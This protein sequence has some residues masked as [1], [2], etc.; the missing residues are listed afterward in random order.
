MNVSR[1]SLLSFASLG[2]FALLT[3]TGC[4]RYAPYDGEFFDCECGT[5]VWDGRELGMRMAE[6][7][8]LDSTTYRYHVIADLR[9]QEELDARMEPRNVI[10]T[11]TTSFVGAS[12]SLSLEAGD[13][14]MTVQEVD[15]PG[16]EVPWTMNGA[17]LAISASEEAHVMT[18]NSLSAKR[19][20]KTVAAS[21][22]FTFEVGD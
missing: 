18:L 12:T 4:T 20:N 22:E 7:E 10:L 21:G 3:W 16:S 9:D 8:Q 15:S 14:A 13:A 2:L 6:V 11:L 1:T 5:L 19:G 17:D